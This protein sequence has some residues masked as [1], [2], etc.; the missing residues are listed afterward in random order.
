MSVQADDLPN[1]LPTGVTLPDGTYLSFP[2]ER[3]CGCESCVRAFEAYRAGE[4]RLPEEDG[5]PW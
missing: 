4:L 5:L 1:R 2:P 3:D